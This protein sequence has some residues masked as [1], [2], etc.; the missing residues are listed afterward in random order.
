MGKQWKLW[1]ILFWGAPKSLQMVTAAMKLRLLLFGR[2]A[3][4]NL[5]SILKSRDIANKGLSYQSCGFPS[6]HVWMWEL[7]C[8]EG[9]APQNWCFWTV[10]LEKTLESPLEI[11]PVHSKGNQSWIFIGRT[12]VEAE[13]LYFDHMM[14]RTDSLEKTLMLGKIEGRR[15]RRW[16]RMR[17][18]MASLTRWT[19]VWASSRSWWCRGKPG[20]AVHWVAKSQTQVSDW[21]KLTE[22]L[23]SLSDHPSDASLLYLPW[24]NFRKYQDNNIRMTR[25]F[26]AKVF[27]TWLCPSHILYNRSILDRL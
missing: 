13:A 7:D 19:W 17:W 24:L 20:A 4:A 25:P 9:W 16:Q 10:V 1:Q 5:D 27:K 2:K 18:W 21:T 6:S 3:M 14:G 15:R 22:N 12:D 23:V 26:S 11:Q 8:E